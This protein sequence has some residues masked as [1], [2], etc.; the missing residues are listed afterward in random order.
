MIARG[1]VV[2]H[3]NFRI[4]RVACLF[5]F[6]VWVIRP[7]DLL[8]GDENGLLVRPPVMRINFER[9]WIWC[10]H[11]EKKLMARDEAFSIDGFHDFVVE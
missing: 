4:A 2:S 5:K 8:H 7:G 9:T 6:M 10:A 3:A 11:R 1:S